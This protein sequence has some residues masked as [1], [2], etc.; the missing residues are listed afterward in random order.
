VRVVIE[1]PND[2]EL[3]EALLEAVTGINATIL[4]RVGE[5][6]GEAPPLLY[7]AG[8]RYKRE[9]SGREEWQTVL[10]NMARGLGDCEDLATHRAAELRVYD[11]EPARAVV[12]RTG[13]RTLHAVVER[14]DGTIEDPSK[15][16]GMRRRG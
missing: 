13:P 4:S 16:L 2:P 11:G 9:P 6:M 8:I 15:L 5:V 1:V 10:G 3:L 14:A 12:R 7:D